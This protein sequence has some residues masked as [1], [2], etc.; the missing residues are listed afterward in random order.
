MLR[1]YKEYTSG[2]LSFY[3]LQEWF[4]ICDGHAVSNK[5]NMLKTLMNDVLK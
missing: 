4:V 3:Y 5:L 2:A 1:K